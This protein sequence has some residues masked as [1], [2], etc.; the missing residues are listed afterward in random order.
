[1]HE[2]K[3]RA[4]L[5]RLAGDQGDDLAQEAFLAAWRAAGSWKGEGSYFAWLA[6]IAW[7]QFL[8]HKRSE[9]P[10]ETLDEAEGLSVQPCAARRSAVDQAM[11]RLPERE[12]MAALL[13]FAEGYSHNEAAMIMEVPLGTLKS[14]VARAR[15]GLVDC[16]EDEHERA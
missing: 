10:T 13:C 3:L 2:P 9:K 6:R 1:M 5:R 4:M 8:S 11:R 15:S 7:R 16:L 12:R 14:L